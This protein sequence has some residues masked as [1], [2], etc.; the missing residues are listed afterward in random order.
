MAKRLG[1]YKRGDVF[2]MSHRQEGKRRWISLQT[3]DLAEALT[4]AQ[5]IRDR[6]I[7]PFKG[8]ICE[9]IPRFI[10]FKKRNNIYSRESQESKFYILRQLG[11][12]FPD[13]PASNITEKQMQLWYDEL[14]RQIKPSTAESYLMAA[15]SFFKWCIDIERIR[16]TNP[17]R[18]VRV[19]RV[20]RKARLR[21]CTPE[22]RDILI[23]NTKDADLKFIMHCGFYAGLRKNEIIE[24]RAD[25]F[26]LKNGLV[27]V[28]KTNTFRPKDR[29][30]RSIPLAKAFANFLRAY[31]PENGFCL[32]PEVPHGRAHYRYDFRFPFKQYMKSQ[33]MLWVTPHIMRHTF[34]SILASR[35][36]SIF[37]IS[38]WLGDDVR[39]TQRHYA[40][41][42]PGDRDIEKLIADNRPAP[43]DVHS[44]SNQP[45]YTALLYADERPA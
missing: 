25:W 6:P 2:W 31:L 38:E 4:R 40:K 36:V 16:G 27:H 28:R 5:E 29:D 43:G 44:S 20:D 8:T 15:R 41:L 21:F 34:A 17:A 24:A 45:A 22:Q 12:R 11:K 42:L 1:I 33:K 32:K 39:V 10:E 30:E 18:T 35:G 14:A 13:V 23:A 9:L 19:I 3:T 37:K 7:T 26:D